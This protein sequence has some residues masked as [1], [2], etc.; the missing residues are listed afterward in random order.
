MSHFVVSK[1]TPVLN[2]SDFKGVFCENM[3]FDNRGLIQEIEMIALSGMVFKL[4]KSLLD[5]IIEVTSEDYPTRR[6]IFVDQRF[7]RLEDTPTPFVRS[8]PPLLS[9]IERMK[10]CVDI[11]YMWGGNC[12]TGIPEWKHYYPPPQRVLTTKEELYWTFK[13]LDCSGLLYEVTDGYVP[14]NT[15]EQKAIG[16]K[17]SIDSAFKPLDLFFFPGHVFVC[18]NETEVIESSLSCGGVVVTSLQN[19][20]K[21]VN[22]RDLVV[23]RFHP[24]TLD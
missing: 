21:E 9:I 5:D 10:K 20:L 14:R 17:L 3:P 6:K 23:K 7:G 4:E 15:S 16:Q 11:P 8:C 1:P 12:S 24:E 2:T 22:M 18:L 19:R 13:G